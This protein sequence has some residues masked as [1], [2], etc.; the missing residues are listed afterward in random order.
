MTKFYLKRNNKLKIIYP[1]PIFLNFLYFLCVF[2]I[3]IFVFLK[4]DYLFCC[5][6]IM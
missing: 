5:D 1:I 4:R 6:E 2:F 3:F